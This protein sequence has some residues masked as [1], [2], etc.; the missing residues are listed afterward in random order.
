[1]TPSDEIHIPDERELQRRM[2]IQNSQGIRQKSLRRLIGLSHLVQTE[3]HE[4]GEVYQEWADR[5]KETVNT[6]LANFTREL[7]VEDY[8]R[9][10]EASADYFDETAPGLLEV[11]DRTAED[12]LKTLRAVMFS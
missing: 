11:S 6:S 3:Y 10:T 5:K 2:A 12:Y 7:R 8:H 9:L 1:M 4:R